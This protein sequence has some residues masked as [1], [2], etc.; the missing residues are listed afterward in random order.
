MS[1]EPKDLQGNII[2]ALSRAGLECAGK[3]VEFTFLNIGAVFERAQKFS[4]VK[5]PSEFAEVL[6]NTTREQFEALSEQI[7]ELGEVTQKILPRT[8]A[9]PRSSFWE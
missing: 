9:E 1:L 7:E 4:N 6:S 5:S 3:L 8:A 2:W